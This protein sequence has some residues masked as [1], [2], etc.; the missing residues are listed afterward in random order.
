[1]D[2]FWVSC[3]RA[4][5]A[6]EQ[7]AIVHNCMSS[8]Q[9]VELTLASAAFLPVRHNTVLGIII[10]EGDNRR[11]YQNIAKVANGPMIWPDL[12]DISAWPQRH[13]YLY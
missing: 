9:R 13:A 4:Y 12:N 7:Y 10:C 1:M 3:S 6:A 8:E 5:R 11:E 2:S